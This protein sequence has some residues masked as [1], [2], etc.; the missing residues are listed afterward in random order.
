MNEGFS[1]MLFEQSRAYLVF[2]EKEGISPATLKD[3]RRALKRFVSFVAER[4]ERD[5]FTETFLEQF[6]AACG[7][8]NV[9]KAVR[10]FSRY[11]YQ[12][13]VIDT[14]MGHYHRKLPEPFSSYLSYVVD[15][16]PNNPWPYRIVLT[17]FSEYLSK[18]SLTLEE[19]TLDRLDRFMGDAYD[20]LT[21]ETR[22]K[23]RSCLRGFLKHL[24]MTGLIRKDLSF[25]LRNKRVF[26]RNLPPRHLT[27]EEI[28]LLF[29]RM[30]FDTERDLRAN[31]TGPSG[32]CHGLPGL[33]PG[34]ETKGGQSYDNR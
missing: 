31:R 14:A 19:I 32:Q 33:Y 11:L 25:F 20:H 17:A 2:L 5:V 24:F 28:R 10:P 21:V 26:E 16:Y 7:R 9:K 34:P 22:N 29:D 4:D 27:R 30:R 12:K 15:L 23:Y 6:Q 1:H 8:T 13:G 18:R 3:K